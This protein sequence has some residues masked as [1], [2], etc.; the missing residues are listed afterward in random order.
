MPH[1]L[2]G[3]HL[4]VL[5]IYYIPDIGIPVAGA[6]H[7]SVG[8]GSPVD[9][10]DS[11]VVLVKHSSLLPSLALSIVQSD[12]LAVVGQGQ[13]IPVPRPR[14]TGDGSGS[15]LMNG[16]HSGKMPLVDSVQSTQAILA[17]L[18]H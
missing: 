4:Y 9:T 17:Q 7:N 3:T 13:L 14:V 12:V 8:G 15:K 11:Q 1:T 6:S 10:S 16:G 18:P 5:Y 2:E